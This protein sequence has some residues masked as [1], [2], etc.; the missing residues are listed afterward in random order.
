MGEAA[1]SREAGQED[2]EEESDA[3]LNQMLMQVTE[4]EQRDHDMNCVRNIKTP[5]VRNPY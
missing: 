3:K 1:N 2:V 5:S 4:L